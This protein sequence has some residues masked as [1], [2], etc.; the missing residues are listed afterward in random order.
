M[1]VIAVVAAS[2]ALVGSIN[3]ATGPAVVSA[4]REAGTEPAPQGAV[5]SP[6]S[7]PA[8][9]AAGAAPESRASEGAGR[10]RQPA[11]APAEG[12]PLVITGL[13]VAGTTMLGMSAGEVAS[14]LLPG[15]VGDLAGPEEGPADADPVR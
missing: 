7:V 3:A 11:A 1:L 8:R 6:R 10:G 4:D 2:P 15:R 14:V 5:T 12:R 9:K 13:I